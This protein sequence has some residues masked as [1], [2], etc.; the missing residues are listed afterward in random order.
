MVFRMVDADEVAPLRPAV[1][2]DVDEVVLPWLR[3][4]ILSEVLQCHGIIVGLLIPW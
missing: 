3:Q 4:V 1:R 2:L